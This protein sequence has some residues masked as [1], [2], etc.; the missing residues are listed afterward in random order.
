MSILP[1][2]FTFDLERQVIQKS[3]QI[4]TLDV[5]ATSICKLLSAVSKK[6]FDKK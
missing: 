4:I 2:K 3:P 1:S 5:R 6:K